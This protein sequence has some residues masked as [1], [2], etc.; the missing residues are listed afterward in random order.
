MNVLK[1]F[2]V[3]VFKTLKEKKYYWTRNAFFL[4][5]PLFFIII[6]LFSGSSSDFKNGNYSAS[7][8][9]YLH[10]NEVRRKFIN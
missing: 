2:K 3:F 1:T 4:F 6:Y 10:L 8:K 5:F 9:T 7:A